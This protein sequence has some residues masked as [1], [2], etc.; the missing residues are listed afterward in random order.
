MENK[1]WKN[2]YKCKKAFFQENTFYQNNI[3][4]KEGQMDNLKDI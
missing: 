2:N 4:T 1:K 3:S